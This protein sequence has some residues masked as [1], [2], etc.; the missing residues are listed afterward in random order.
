MKQ[1]TKMEILIQNYP[2]NRNYESLYIFKLTNPK[3]SANSLRIEVPSVI[4]QG[5]NGISCDSELSSTSKDYFMFLTLKNVT[6]L[7]CS[8][9]GQSI[10]INGLSAIITAL[11]D[12]EFLFLDVF[13]LKNPDI[14]VDRSEFK[15][16]FLNIT[17][18]TGTVIGTMTQNLPYK[19]S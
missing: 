8:M 14:S 11:K 19:V 15:F 7:T 3:I 13:G 12:D 4:T 18:S 6:V 10:L 9:D 2:Y 5:P 1:L 17:D 16:T